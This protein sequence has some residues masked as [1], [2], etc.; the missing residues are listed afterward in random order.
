MFISL[1]VVFVECE[2]EA[3]PVS[4]LAIS[5]RL[6]STWSDGSGTF[7]VWSAVITN[8]GEEI[9]FDCNIVPDK[10]SFGL[11]QQDDYWGIAKKADRAFGFPEYIRIY[12]ISQG[13]NLKFGYINRGTNPMRWNFMNIQ[14]QSQSQ[15]LN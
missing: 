15:T 8:K 13:E 6:T 12:G 3:F 1:Y 7:S 10:N 2:E 4:P 5:Q 14:F 9:I 11:R